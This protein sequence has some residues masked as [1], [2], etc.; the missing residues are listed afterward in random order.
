MLTTM[1]AK[2]IGTR[3]EFRQTSVHI[4]PPLPSNNAGSLRKNE[5][6]VTFQ[7]CLGGRGA[8]LLLL[9][10]LNGRI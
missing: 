7:H 6:E 8:F 5:P 2:T 1:T 3:H 10:A 9:Q 4:L